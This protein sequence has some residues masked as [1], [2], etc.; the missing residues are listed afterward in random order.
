MIHPKLIMLCQ[1]DQIYVIVKMAPILLY[2][3]GYNVPTLLSFPSSVVHLLLWP[4]T[5]ISAIPK[6]HL[7]VML[8]L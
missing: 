5:A 7:Y 4:Q 3:K 2:T 8:G 1:S 6:L